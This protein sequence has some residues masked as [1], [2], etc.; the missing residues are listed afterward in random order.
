MIT[1]DE[2]YKKLRLVKMNEANISD[3]EKTIIG[4]RA[5]ATCVGILLYNEKHKVAIVAHSSSE[6]ENI[7]IQ[8]ED[9]IKNNNLDSSTIKYK[10]ISGSYYNHYNIFSIL[11][12]YF[13]NKYPLF[14]PYENIPNNAI[15]YEKEFDS[16]MFI[17]DAD[18]GEF[19]TKNYFVIN[20]NLDSQKIKR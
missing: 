18:K 1:S 19:L 14:V 10:I 8:I 9:L 11:E 6:W 16:N 15:I 13:K 4:T 17:F 12:N 5:L 20:D 7:I 3:S 2:F